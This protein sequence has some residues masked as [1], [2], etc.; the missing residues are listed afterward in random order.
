M[1]RIQGLV[2][3]SWQK[4]RLLSALFVAV[5]L[6]G[7]LSNLLF[8]DTAFSGICESRV[9]ISQSEGIAFEGLTLTMFLEIDAM[10]FSTHAVFEGPSFSTFQIRGMGDLGEI[11]VNSVV[12]LT[13]SELE[14]DFWQTSLS[15]DLFGLELRD[16]LYLTTPQ[17]SSYNQLSWATS[18]DM[19][20]TRGTLEFD[21][22]PPAFS[23][24]NTCAT[25]DWPECDTSV[26]GCLTFDADEGFNA[27]TISLA[28]YM[29]FE[30]VMG[31]SGSLSATILFTLEEKVFTPTL[32]LTPDWFICSEIDILA[33]FGMAPSSAPTVDSALI[34]GIKGGFTSGAVTVRFAESL[35]ESK[36]SSVTGK[37]DYFEQLGL[38][39]DIPGC[40]GPPG[41]L[42]FD[43]YFERVPSGML[44]SWGLMTMSAQIHLVD[45]V[46]FILDMQLAKDEPKWAFSFSTKIFW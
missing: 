7:G 46:S 4:L 8:A 45:G 22:Y 38:S 16:V 34:Y 35:S 3:P 41:S 20:S 13:P 43:A 33:E 21:L 31:V 40:C 18:G 42:S 5:A 12:S 15:V 17:T 27:A 11:S 32:N 14:F 37:A 30:D 23:A 1:T 9:G 28:D 10:T 24:V 25:F 2:H 6:I 44:F 29:L 19:I 39:V 26:T 36:N